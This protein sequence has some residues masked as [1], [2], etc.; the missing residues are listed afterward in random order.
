MLIEKRMYA[1]ESKASII[2]VPQV[3]CSLVLQHGGMTEALSRLA[4]LKLT[5]CRVPN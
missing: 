5:M 3:A 2:T 4:K 1:D